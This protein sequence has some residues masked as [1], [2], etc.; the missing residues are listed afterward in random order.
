MEWEEEQQISLWEMARNAKAMKEAL[1]LERKRELYYAELYDDIRLFS[2]RYADKTDPRG[3]SP[4]VED[5]ALDIIDAK[6][7]YE[8]RISK[9]KRRHDNWTSFLR[10][11]DTFAADALEQHFEHGVDVSK[12]S[13]I[14]AIEEACKRWNAASNGLGK[15]LDKQT[16]AYYEYVKKKYP[17]LFVKKP[18]RDYYTA[19]EYSNAL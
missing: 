11:M 7:A 9:L 1:E 12:D 6:N 8:L 18:F 5:Q 16:V 2:I 15:V 3:L 10:S 19:N 14:P 17:E 13:L 4:S